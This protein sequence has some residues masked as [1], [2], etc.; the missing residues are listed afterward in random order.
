MI[1]YID[2]FCQHVTMP[3]VLVMDQASIHTSDAIADKIPEWRD[4]GV[5]IFYLPTSSPHLH[6]IEILW[7]SRDSES[8]ARH[9]H[10]SWHYETLF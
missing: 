3:T 9:A 4:K 2:E 8:S 6:R 1:A 5:E 7:R 10:Y